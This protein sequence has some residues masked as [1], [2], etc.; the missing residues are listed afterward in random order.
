[1]NIRQQAF[2]ARRHEDAL[3]PA[4]ICRACFHSYGRRCFLAPLS[5]GMGETAYMKSLMAA[6]WSRRDGAGSPASTRLTRHAGII[7]GTALGDIS[8]RQ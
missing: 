4:S 5:H 6:R 8:A 3:S 7:A 2:P 1:M